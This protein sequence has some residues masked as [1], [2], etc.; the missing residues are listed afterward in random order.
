MNDN[1]SQE[2]NDNKSQGSLKREGFPTREGVVGSPRPTDAIGDALRPQTVGFPTTEIILENQGSYGCIFRPELKCDGTIGDPHYVSKIQKD[3]ESLK[4]ETTLGKKIAQINKYQYYFAPI[5]NQCFVSLDKIQDSEKEKCKILQDATTAEQPIKEN[6]NHEYMSTKIRYVSNLNIDNYLQSLPKQLYEKKWE[7][8][9]Y[10]L[11][12]SIKKLNAQNI[13]HLD[14]KEKNIMYDKMMHNPIIIDFGISF[15]CTSPATSDIFYTDTYYPYWC[16]DIY[17]ICDIITKN[18]NTQTIVKEELEELIERFFLE[19]FETNKKFIVPI[20]EEEKAPLI[21][22]HSKF[23]SSFIGKTYKELVEH[24]Y[25][26]E[27]YLS[28]D[29]YSLCI[30]YLFI[31]FTDATSLSSQLEPSSK[32]S[33]SQVNSNGQDQSQLQDILHKIIRANP[34]ERKALIEN[35]K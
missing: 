2:M 16:I 21:E 3:V 12:N 7:S 33:A 24:L 20:K 5:E 31:R 32:T 26:P 15:D 35:L 8:T 1:K 27:Y 14:I 28:W 6:P 22:N 23:F 4:N 29:L 34:A 17:I 10:Y 19:F 18:R 13:I 9:F 11:V 30:T 25:R